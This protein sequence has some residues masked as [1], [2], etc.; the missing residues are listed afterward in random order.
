MPRVRRAI[1]AFAFAAALAS[2][3]ATPADARMSILYDVVDGVN[4]LTG[5]TAG[6][7]ALGPETDGLFQQSIATRGDV[8]PGPPENPRD[9]GRF[10]A[11]VL[12][13]APRPNENCSN[14]YLSAPDGSPRSAESMADLIRDGDGWSPA[15][16]C[17][18]SSPPAPRQLGVGTF[19][20]RL[21]FLDEPANVR[22][23]L[24]PEMSANFS[25]AITSLASEPAAGVPDAGLYDTPPTVAERVHSYVRFPQSLTTF[26]DRWADLWAALPKV[27]GV[28]LEL[29]GYENDATRAWEEVHYATWT[30]PFAREFM[31]RGGDLRRLHLLMTASRRSAEADPSREPGDQW[32][33]ARTGAACELLENG[34]G[35][36][37]VSRGGDA[38]R[39]FGAG[40]RETFSPGGTISEAPAPPDLSSSPVECTAAFRLTGATSPTAGQ[41]AEF[42]RKLGR[43][44]IEL[45]AGSVTRT[46]GAA[47]T[48]VEIDVAAGLPE[49][50]ERR[51]AHDS[52]ATVAAGT[53][54]PVPVD[55]DGVA[56]LMLAGPPDPQTDFTLEGLR[57]AALLDSVRGA[58]GRQPDPHLTLL[59]PG[60]R[61]P[62]ERIEGECENI[63]APQP[64]R[65]WLPA[66]DAFNWLLSSTTL[67]APVAALTE[68][69]PAAPGGPAASG[70]PAAGPGEPPSAGSTEAAATR[71]PPPTAAGTVG[72]GPAPSR[73]RTENARIR[74]TREALIIQQ[75]IDAAALRRLNA[76]NAWIDEGVTPAD[77][78]GGAFGP[79]AF[80]GAVEWAGGAQTTGTGAPSPRPLRIARRTTRRNV[81]TLSVR[82]VQINDRISRAL[83]RRAVATAQRF[84]DLTGGNLAAGTVIG[85]RVL[86][87]GLA[88][89]GVQ[90]AGVDLPARRLDVAR[91]ATGSTLRLTSAQLR[92][93]QRRSQRAIAIANRVNDTIARGLTEAEFRAG[94][95]GTNRIVVISP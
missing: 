2:A 34:P 81:I 57:G 3:L 87:K 38:W 37:R 49:W 92:R 5:P 9:G 75:R 11:K 4:T 42:V 25:A 60:G 72:C 74:L 26:P 35:A 12:P 68:A 76:A 51:F 21:V 6:P 58:G 7:G 84:R 53:A 19:D 41:F 47:E 59:C 15:P 54:V 73:R 82:Q 39:E 32:P 62:G 66:D 29:Y 64:G 23:D 55:E 8:F 40:F 20:S 18:E 46:P 91:P 65:E 90:R 70:N 16:N 79:G 44:A 83:H 95:I 28:W 14:A 33:W 45:P 86:Y 77:L 50:L 78:C 80:S 43:G 48:R 56:R 1:A 52:G 30:R 88:S 24:A 67:A 69:V 27:G 10:V 63:I 13:K 22:S 36:Y 85:D 17:V 71:P 94:S 61:L 93:T 31:S 89:T